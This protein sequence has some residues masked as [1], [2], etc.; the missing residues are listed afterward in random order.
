MK[1]VFAIVFSVLLVGIQFLAGSAVASPA[2][3][4]ECAC[5][6]QT[7]CVSQSP[8]PAPQTPATPTRELSQNQLQ[9]IAS[10][11]RAALELPAPEEAPLPDPVFSSPK[12]ASVPLYEW[13]C[14]YLI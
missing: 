8:A 2:K 3:V 11:F 7:C 14:S 1:R 4:C 10:F 6:A 13:H 9:F 5:P 12:G